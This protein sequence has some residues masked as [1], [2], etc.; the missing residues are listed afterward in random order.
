MLL[1]AQ[2]GQLIVPPV[3][4]GH[5]A[6]GLDHWVGEFSTRPTSAARC[7][8]VPD[9]STRVAVTEVRKIWPA[10]GTRSGH[11]LPALDSPAVSKSHACGSYCLPLAAECLDGLV[12]AIA[13]HFQ[14]AVEEIETLPAKVWF[15]FG[16]AVGAEDEV[17]KAICGGGRGLSEV[18]VC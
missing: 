10:A 14:Q 7:S 15:L 8:A 11:T 2:R 9:R 16:L 5:V 3:W 1:D 17:A 6:G 13:A 4:L 12:G 18:A